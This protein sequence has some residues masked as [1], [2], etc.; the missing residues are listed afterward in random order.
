[1]AKLLTQVLSE[2]F[3]IEAWKVLNKFYKI[4]CK[5]GKTVENEK[6]WVAHLATELDSQVINPTLP[7]PDPRTGKS[8]LE[9]WQLEQVSKQVEASQQLDGSSTVLISASWLKPM[10][11]EIKYLR[12]IEETDFEKDFNLLADTIETVCRLE[13][14][15]EAYVSILMDAVRRLAEDKKQP[16]DPEVQAVIKLEDLRGAAEAMQMS[17]LNNNNAFVAAINT[18]LA[19]KTVMAELKSFAETNEKLAD[20]RENGIAQ[21]HANLA[22]AGA[23]RSA[24]RLIEDH[25]NKL[26]V[27]PNCGSEQIDKSA[28]I[29]CDN[30]RDYWTVK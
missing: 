24:A 7:F 12:S 16:E 28:Y 15:D 2:H 8:F 23:F 27:C 22:A 11:R 1:M 20:R 10:L 9:S 4:S 29:F 13:D 6:D 18:L 17:G 5:C 21:K 14:K 19:M 30:C 25:F 26:K 3:P